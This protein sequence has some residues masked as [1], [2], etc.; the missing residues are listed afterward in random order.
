MRRGAPP[1]G[2]LIVDGAHKLIRIQVFAGRHA[3][4]SC[5]STAQPLCALR[6]QHNCERTSLASHAPLLIVALLYAIVQVC[7]APDTAAD[8]IMLRHLD[9]TRCTMVAVVHELH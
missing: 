4:D 3:Q 9:L 8:L 7:S 1:C 6:P 5:Q 2:A